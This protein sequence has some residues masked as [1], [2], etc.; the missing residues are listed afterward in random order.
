[1][2]WIILYAIGWLI[3]APILARV[4]AHADRRLRGQPG[5]E[6]DADTWVY[7]AGMGSLAAVFWP[8]V[9]PFGLDALPATPRPP[10]GESSAARVGRPSPTRH[11]AWRSP[12]RTTRERSPGFEPTARIERRPDE[13]RRPMVRLLLGVW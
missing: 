6:P 1:M 9:A 12:P 7:A 11:Q 5:P 10:A 3:A 13:H 4:I 8:L 2:T